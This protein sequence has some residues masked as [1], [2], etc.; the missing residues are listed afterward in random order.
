MNRT[1]LISLIVLGLLC[2]NAYSQGLTASLNEDS[3]VVISGT[4]DPLVG[5]ELQSAAGLLVPVPG[6]DASPFQLLLANTPSQIAYAAPSAPVELDG[7][8]VLAVGYDGTLEQFNQDVTGEWGGTVASVGGTIDV[9]S[10]ATP[11]VPE[12]SGLAILLGMLL[13]GTKRRRRTN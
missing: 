7:N 4:S 2:C 12:P 11:L 8:L 13:L 9:S 3:F 6:N 1:S 10:P 5:F